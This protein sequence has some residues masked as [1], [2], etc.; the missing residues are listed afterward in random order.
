MTRP[1]AW[2]RLKRFRPSRLVDSALAVRFLEYLKCL[3][4]YR[5]GETMRLWVDNSAGVIGRPRVSI[6]IIHSCYYGAHA[7]D[8]EEPVSLAGGEKEGARRRAADQC[9]DITYP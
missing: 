2:V 8:R 3:F 6:G 1:A 5:L 4:L 9:I 7:V